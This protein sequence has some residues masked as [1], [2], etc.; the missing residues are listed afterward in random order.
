MKIKHPNREHKIKDSVLRDLVEAIR[1]GVKV[2]VYLNTKFGEV[3]ANLL[4][5]PWAKRLR[6]AGV[7]VT[8]FSPSRRWHGK[9]LIVDERYILEGSANWSVDANGQAPP[10]SFREG[11]VVYSG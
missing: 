7:K 1:R 5:K 6:E 2:E 8:G 4:E 10:G 9:I 11:P 3:E